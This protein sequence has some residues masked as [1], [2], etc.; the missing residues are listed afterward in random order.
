MDWGSVFCPSPSVDVSD[1][2]CKSSVWQKHDNGFDRVSYFYKK[3]NKHQKNYSSVEKE[4]LAMALL[5][6][7]VYMYIK[8]MICYY[9]Y[10]FF[11][12]T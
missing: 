1:N 10:T 12:V 6:Y 2:R 3:F 7:S 11:V 4:A 5:H 9:M 8:F